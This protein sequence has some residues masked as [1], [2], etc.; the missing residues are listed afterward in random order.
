[1]GQNDG[2][3]IKISGTLETGRR[4]GHEWGLPRGQE[5]GEDIRNTMTGREGPGHGYAEVENL[6]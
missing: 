1:M 4:N 2:H 6:E 3:L 5:H